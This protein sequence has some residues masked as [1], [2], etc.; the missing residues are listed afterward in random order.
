MYDGKDFF[1][2]DPKIDVCENGDEIIT[3]YTLPDGLKITNIGKKYPDFNAYEWVNWLEMTGEGES[4]LISELND[5]D[6]LVPF[7]SDPARRHTAYLPD[8]ELDMKIYS[9][10]GSNIREDN[11]YCDADETEVFRYKNHIYMGE[12]R[13]F[14]NAGGRSSN[15]TAPYFNVF[16]QNRGVIFAV[17]WTGQWNCKLERREDG[18]GIKTKIEDTHF[19]LHAGEKIR[20]S[21]FVIMNYECDRDESQNK[22]RRFLRKHFSV[23][24]DG[25]T[26]PLSC[27]IWGGVKSEKAIEKIEYIKENKLPYEYIWI[28]ASWHGTS[29]NDSPDE[30]EGDWG[31]QVG[32]WRPNKKIHP[33]GIS[34]VSRAAHEAGKKFI[35]WFEPERAFR[36]TPSVINN[37]EY[38][39]PS[40]KG[41]PRSLLDLGN[42]EAW[43]YCFDTLSSVI[44]EGN[45]D[46][47]RQDFN[48]NPLIFWR[49][50][51]TE[52]RRGMT[53]IRHINGLYRLWDAL[54]ER[55]PE[56]LIDN[57]SSGGKRLDIEMVRRSVPLWR[58][59]VQCSANYV[60]EVAQVHNMNYALWMPYSGTGAGRVWC[61]TYRIRSAYSGAMVT[62]HIYT[63]N[64]PLEKDPERI[65]WLRK[66][67]NE[68]LSVR[69]YFYEDFYPLTDSVMARLS[70]CASQYNRPEIGDG[71]V[72]VFKRENSPFVK[73]SFKLRGLD[74]EKTYEVRDADGGSWQYSGRQLAEGFSVT[75][76]E[77]RTAKLYFYKSIS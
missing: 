34:E 12:K 40:P 25:E 72:Q 69:E 49:S 74:P 15:G 4:K 30:F 6:I 17:G 33:N 7:P 19:K 14:C 58:S 77:D 9:P 53:E 71:I 50:A 61:D 10:K 3:I 52:D 18:L 67:L 11:F 43:Q 38:Y 60:P 64:M 20:T 27:I 51:D 13:E 47:Y 55:F 31:E 68:Y 16:R 54:L 63:E 24:G 1:E 42:D 36:E 29:E 37:P 32:D 44:E 21:S 73:A 28:E 76:K 26:M 2:H 66:Y 62:N 5:S 8:G 46:C 57:C 23:L 22:W 70:W 41:S 65:A 59:D 56:L 75:V 48:T 45:V 35:L 39:I